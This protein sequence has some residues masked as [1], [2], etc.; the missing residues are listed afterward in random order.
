MTKRSP[1]NSVQNY[2]KLSQNY[3]FMQKIIKRYAYD[4]E[5]STRTPESTEML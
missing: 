3:V 4:R 2:V 5:V 1:A